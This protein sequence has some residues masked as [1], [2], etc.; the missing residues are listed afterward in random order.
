MAT[1]W[2]EFMR[3]EGFDRLV[4]ARKLSED[5]SKNDPEDDPFRSKYKARE[6]ISDLKK[7]VTD[8]VESHPEDL[9]LKFFKAAFHLKLGSNY[10]GE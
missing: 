1:E 4:E 8:R 5:E 6:I 7:Q 9:S 3:S 10:I 2:L